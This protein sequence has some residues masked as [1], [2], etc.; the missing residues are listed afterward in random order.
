[1]ASVL[2]QRIQAR[3]NSE[4]NLSDA[5]QLEEGLQRFQNILSVRDKLNRRVAG[6][7]TF[8]TRF[9][10]VSLASLV[11][12][13]VLFMLV[14]SSKVADLSYSIYSVEQNYAKVSNN[15]ALMN[16][17]IQ[18]V[19]G[20][21]HTIAEM[22]TVLKKVDQE[23][24]TLTMNMGKL[25]HNL[26]NVTTSLYGMQAS[27]KQIDDSFNQMEHSVYQLQSDVRDISKPVRFINKFMGR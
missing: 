6:R 10:M 22:S 5:L 23:T 26:S 16:S 11:V 21:I 13:F 19:R 18:E 7:L 12:A 9:T 27:A 8:L 15:I 14:M 1:M 24:T 3:I 20:N 25:N 4:E 2:Q 17:G